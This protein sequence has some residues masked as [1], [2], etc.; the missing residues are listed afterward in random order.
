MSICLQKFGLKKHFYSGQLLFYDI[1]LLYIHSV[2][3]YL[4]KWHGNYYSDC[5]RWLISLS[6]DTFM[7]VNLDFLIRRISFPTIYNMSCS[8]IPKGPQSLI[9]LFTIFVI[10]IIWFSMFHCPCYSS[11]D[12][13]SYT[14]NIPIFVNNSGFLKSRHPWRNRT[15]TKI[16][17]PRSYL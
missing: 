14:C 1:S 8:L 3:I 10:I 15:V 9:S 17:G 16:I 11:S 7:H 12:T 13:V 2:A 4:K 6:K 5:R